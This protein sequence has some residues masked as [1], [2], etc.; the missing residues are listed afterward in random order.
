M[1][2]ITRYDEELYKAADWLLQCTSKK[3]TASIIDRILAG[4]TPE[5]LETVIRSFFLIPSKSL[6]KR[7]KKVGGSVDHL[8]IRLYK[9][10]ELA[11]CLHDFADEDNIDELMDGY[12]L[13]IGMTKE[14]IEK[15]TDFIAFLQNRKYLR[16]NNS[17]NI[18]NPW[19]GARFMKCFN[20]TDK[21]KNL[22]ELYKALQHSFKSRL[23]LAASASTRQWPVEIITASDAHAQYMKLNQVAGLCAAIRKWFG[24]DRQFVIDGADSGLT[25]LITS[26]ASISEMLFN[27]FKTNPTI[28]V[29][30]LGPCLNEFVQNLNI[31]TTS[32][33]SHIVD[34]NIFDSATIGNIRNIDSRPT[35]NIYRADQGY[36]IELKGII[37]IP[38]RDSRVSVTI[39]DVTS[40]TDF[41]LSK[42][43][44]SKSFSTA[45][46]STMITLTG[47]SATHPVTLNDQVMTFSRPLKLALKRAGDWGQVEHCSKYGKVFITSDKM[48][49]M[50]AYYRKVDCIFL[51]RQESRFGTMQN[52]FRYI[53]VL[54]TGFRPRT[55]S[56][57]GS[58]SA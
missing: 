13:P 15:E 42:N 21:H 51:R 1:E 56:P 4:L 26:I 28:A 45:A 36:Q 48:A 11:D 29:S 22:E 43:N 32:W 3:G 24:S 41:Q 6:P 40:T 19:K 23:S 49:A 37:Q 34:A 2:D 52:I 50:Y 12:E 27:R 14:I 5:E 54:T 39:T 18:I 35:G 33:N 58:S 46:I 7:S 53:F 30:A 20:I 47:P 17:P 31:E 16:F 38:G 57:A 55:A 44:T 25:M 9:L 8:D 10:I